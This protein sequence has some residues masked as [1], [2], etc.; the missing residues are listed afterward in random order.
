MKSAAIIVFA[1]VFLFVLDARPAS[2]F[3]SLVSLGTT[4]IA[5]D[6]SCTFLT[7]GQAVCAARTL[8][9]TLVV[10]RFTG[11]AWTGWLDLSG[12]VTSTPSCA[13]DATGKA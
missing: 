1:V 4:Q 2:A 5:P 11:T 6:P 8:K 10:N 3:T 13:G 9:H 7:T 12:I